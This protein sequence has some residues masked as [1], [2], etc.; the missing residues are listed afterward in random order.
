MAEGVVDVLEAIDVEQDHAHLASFPTDQGE[1]G[2]GA[3]DEQSAVGEVGQGVMEGHVTGAVLG[4]L[5]LGDVV[6]GGE[7]RRLP[8]ELDRSLGHFEPA[9]RVLPV[10]EA[11]VE[12]PRDGVAA[13]AGP[14][15]G[16]DDS[17]V[18]RVRALPEG[19]AQDF[20]QHIPGP[21][22]RED[23]FL[24]A[25]DEEGAGS[26]LREGAEPHLALAQ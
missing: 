3:V 18:V 13:G 1:G 19:T 9:H 24:P 21:A 20:A 6:G 25:I 12:M 16:L 22:V 5:A 15:V 4:L 17:D 10:D 2:F 8:V 14:A 23:D 26:A 7:H 11:D